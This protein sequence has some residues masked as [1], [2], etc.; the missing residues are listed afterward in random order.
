MLCVWYVI[1]C[2][3]FLLPSIMFSRFTHIVSRE[4]VSLLLPN[5]ISLYGYIIFCL[6]IELKLYIGLLA[7]FWLLWLML[8]W[9]FNYKFCVNICFQIP[10]DIYLGLEFLGYMFNLLRNDQSIFHSNC[11]ILYSHQQ[12]TKVPNPCL[13]LLLF[14]YFHIMPS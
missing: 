4:I 6:I 3:W 2:V 13:H 1:L 7:L 8:L 9:I 11:I 14:I 10:L 5:N 12:W